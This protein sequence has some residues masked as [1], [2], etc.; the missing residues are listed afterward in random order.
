MLVFLDII[1]YQNY[2]VG[3][4]RKITKKTQNS[5]HYINGVQFVLIVKYEANLNMIPDL[6]FYLGV[7]VII[8]TILGLITIFA[9]GNG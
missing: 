3:N 9:L 2:C 6:Y 5:R 1:I 8:L 4:V 7:I